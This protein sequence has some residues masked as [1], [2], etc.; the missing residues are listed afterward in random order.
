[1][2]RLDL[3]LYSRPK[4]F[5][6]EWHSSAQDVQDGIVMLGKAHTLSALSLSSFPKVSPYASPLLVWLKDIRGRI[7]NFFLSLCQETMVVM[8]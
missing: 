4:E 6:E 3:G 8:I 5:W 7:F 1:M 2:H